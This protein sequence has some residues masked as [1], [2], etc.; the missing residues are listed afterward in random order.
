MKQFVLLALIAVVAA[1]DH[2]CLPKMVS[3]VEPI[4]PPSVTKITSAASEDFPSIS[5]DISVIEGIAV[6]SPT[7][8]SVESEIESYA[9]SHYDTISLLEYY[10]E[11][12]SEVT[13]PTS[14]QDLVSDFTTLAQAVSLLVSEMNTHSSLYAVQSSLQAA[15]VDFTSIV[16][17]GETSF[18]FSH[19]SLITDE[20]GISEA[21]ISSPSIVTD[22]EVLTTMV[23]LS[24]SL[25]SAVCA[26]TEAAEYYSSA[27]R[28][29]ITARDWTYTTAWEIDTTLVSIESSYP[30]LY[31]ALTAIDYF[32]ASHSSD[33]SAFSRLVTVLDY[34]P[35]IISDVTSFVTSVSPSLS[36]ALTVLSPI[37]QVNSHI[38]TEVT[39]LNVLEATHPSLSCA[40]GTLARDIASHAST[41]SL[42][43]EAISSPLSVTNSYLVSSLEHRYPSVVTA[44][45]DITSVELSHPS[46]S[47]VQSQ[48]TYEEAIVSTLITDAEEV[49]SATSPSLIGDDYDMQKVESILPTITEALHSLSTI[50]QASPS[51]SC[52]ESV[53]A[54]YAATDAT[55]LYTI[56]QAIDSPS[57]VSSTEIAYIASLTA[58]F[59]TLASALRS[60]VSIEYT[61]PQLETIESD[62]TYALVIEPSLTKVYSQVSEYES[63]VTNEVCSFAPASYSK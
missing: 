53:I 54:Q 52:D 40:E 44:Y 57:S 4:P 36:L 21:A 22:V 27:L 9:R 55:A 20:S 47:Y 38:T 56:A 63:I 51:L 42:I 39:Y 14:F 26:L 15:M 16:T 32:L 34:V 12:P 23:S 61:F 37:E 41:V 28:E 31:T 2:S 18:E 17:A 45:E 29:L 24:P 5:S 6:S 19:A 8:L 3:S 10:D 58:E 59:P 13:S 25:S 1:R 7:F 30:T 49:I 11:S 62:L 48:L 60:I 50:I 33:S 46:F 35:S 43:E